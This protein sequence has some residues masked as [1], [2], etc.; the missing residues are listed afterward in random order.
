MSC[1]ANYTQQ[2]SFGAGIG[3]AIKQP[4]GQFAFGSAAHSIPQT[5]AAPAF[6]AGIPPF[7]GA[8]APAF[9]ASAPAPA[10][11]ASAASAPA[12]GAASA[13]APAFGGASGVAPAFGGMPA[14]GAQSAPAFGAASGASAGTGFAFGGI[15][16]LSAC[17][18]SIWCHPNL[19]CGCTCVY[20]NY[21]WERMCVQCMCLCY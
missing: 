15:S 18:R 3:E 6:G 8:S 12:Y 5:A 11:G 13:A 10:F 16:K 19:F 21:T 14:F 9:G 7:G 20:G 4:A 1:S 2:D 17:F